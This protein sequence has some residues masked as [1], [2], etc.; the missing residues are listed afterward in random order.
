MDGLLRI[1]LKA[2]SLGEYWML[3]SDFEISKVQSVRVSFTYAYRER[4]VCQSLLWPPIYIG[5][6]DYYV[7]RRADRGPLGLGDATR[8]N[9]C[10]ECFTTMNSTFFGPR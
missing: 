8:R 2:Q 7:S 9:A 5:V 10:L 6:L 3:G 1:R 4:E